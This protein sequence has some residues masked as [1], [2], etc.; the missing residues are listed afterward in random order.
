MAGYFDRINVVIDVVTKS[1]TQALGDFRKSVSEAEG[2]TGKLKAGLGQLKSNGP[3]FAASVGA[4]AGAVTGLAGAA[5]AAGDK[6]VSLA[7][8][9]RNLGTATGLTT[10]EASRLIEV[11]GDLG[12]DASQ[13]QGTLGKIPKTLDSGKWEEYGIATRD[14]G[15][16]LRSTNE[17]LLDGIDYLGKIK[18]PTARAQVGIDLFGKSWG[19]LAPLIGKTRTELDGMLESVS[20]S[21]VITEEETARAENLAA[22]QDSLADAFEDVTLTVGQLVARLSPLLKGIATTVE[23]IIDAADALGL[24]DEAVSGNTRVLD[25]YGKDI[26]AMGTAWDLALE[27]AFRPANQMLD[28]QGNLLVFVDKAAYDKYMTDKALAVVQAQVRGALGQAND[29]LKE[30]AQKLAETGLAA[31]DTADTL[32]YNRDSLARAAYEAE[33]RLRQLRDEIDGKKTWNDL[34]LDI[35]GV[36]EEIENLNRDLEDKKITAEEY[37]LALENVFLDG[38]QGILDFVETLDREVPTE[39]VTDLLAD[40]RAGDIRAVLARLQSLV[41]QNPLTSRLNVVGGQTSIPS[42]V[43]DGSI[44]NNGTY[45]TVNIGVSG[46]PIETG[47]TIIRLINDATAAGGLGNAGRI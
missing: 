22:A 19:N 44:S 1:A 40:F 25:E 23:Q 2:F 27:L 29:A 41:D 14:A 30:Q 31:E 16:K 47:R 18:D 42:S 36:T 7:R 12:G 17:I 8:E 20:S 24:M 11:F 46:D 4:I 35:I 21:K 39:V 28:E 6:F 10:E 38:E 43:R 13:L 37:G 45:V 34:Q 26:D 32:A 15:G 33:T 3:A 9:S 5:L